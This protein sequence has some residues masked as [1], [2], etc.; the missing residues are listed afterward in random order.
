M[1]EEE[2]ALNALDAIRSIIETARAGVGFK[3]TLYRSVLS[4][5]AVATIS[6]QQQEQQSIAAPDWRSDPLGAA[7]TI[8]AQMVAQAL[9]RAPPRSS[10]EHDE[11]RNILLCGGDGAA[12]ASDASALLIAAGVHDANAVD[13]LIGADVLDA[14]EIAF[15]RLL[16]VQG[17]RSKGED[18]VDLFTSSLV[19][20]DLS[21]VIN[22][23]LDDDDGEEGGINTP[24]STIPLALPSPQTSFAGPPPT[25]ATTATATTSPVIVTAAAVLTGDSISQSRPLAQEPM[26]SLQQKR[27]LPPPRRA[28]LRLRPEDSDRLRGFSPEMQ[29]LTSTSPAAAAAAAEDDDDGKGSGGVGVGGV[30]SDRGS[31][32]LARF[33]AEKR[34]QLEIVTKEKASGCGMGGGRFG[35]VLKRAHKK[36]GLL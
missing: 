29:S 14:W 11:A 33:V 24:S 17:R 20:R 8:P 36:A 35:E 25:T 12:R 32:A 26:A 10:E 6:I 7:R 4:A 16:E 1:L 28:I 5:A 31:A 15:G 3:S 18:D 13:V 22:E 30:S 21:A 34:D 27:P 9:S 2:S 19:A 23:L